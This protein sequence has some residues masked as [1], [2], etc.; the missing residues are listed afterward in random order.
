M[1]EER[2][3]QIRIAATTALLVAIAIGIALTAA[4]VWNRAYQVDEVEHI[5]AAYN[6][7][8]GRMIYRDFWQGHNPLL[9]ILLAPV[10]DVRDPVSS[11]RAARIVTG[12]LLL[13][14]I[15]LVAYC[16][17]GLGGTSAALA[18]SALALFHTTLVERGMEVRPDGA[19]GLCTIAALAFEIRERERPLVRYSTQAIILGIGFLFTQKAVFATAAFGCLW[20]VNAWRERRARIVLQPVLLWFMPLAATILIMLPLGCAADFI[21]QN[22]VDAFFAGAGAKERGRFSPLPG[23]LNESLRNPLFVLLAAAGVAWWA[24]RGS[25]RLAFP[26]F[27]AV[28]LTLSLWANPF[29]WPYVH[30]A[31]L[32]VLAV[33]AGCAL[34][35]LD[36]GSRAV[37]TVGLA[38]AMATSMPRLLQDAARGTDSQFALLREIQRVT[39]PDDRL[40]DL[41]GLYFRPD[42]YTSAYAMSGELLTWYAHGGFARMVPE[43]RRNLCAGVIL[44]Y[45]TSALGNEERMFIRTHFVHYW[46]NLFLAGAELTGA[47]RDSVVQFESLKSRAYRYDGDGAITVDGASFLRGTLGTGIH[48]IRIERESATPSRLIMDT[49]APVPARALP[50]TDLYVNFD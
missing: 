27:L 39:A 40:F 9:Y 26:A 28:V 29:P 6:M 46:R 36:R 7:R 30:V 42:A 16:G 13:A 35:A 47:P 34:A 21:Q 25:R 18:A 49:P 50:L 2:R 11:F 15:G 20:L 33:A 3:G 45:R 10:I 12:L 1:Q 38:L 24:T 32:P 23:I 22:I 43:L 19:L 41:V 14:T 37:V 48:T 5:H 31:A 17:R 8:D 4:I 44:N